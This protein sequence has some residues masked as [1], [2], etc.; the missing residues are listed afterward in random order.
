MLS[1]LPLACFY[2]MF[3]EIYKQTG[4]IGETLEIIFAAVLI[5]VG[6]M[7]ILAIGLKLFLD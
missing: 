6:L 3:V 2:L 1:I 5:A 7:A 4:S